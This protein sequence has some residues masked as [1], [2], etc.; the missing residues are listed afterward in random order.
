MQFHPEKSGIVGLN[1]LKAY[2]ALFI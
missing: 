2:G 1:L